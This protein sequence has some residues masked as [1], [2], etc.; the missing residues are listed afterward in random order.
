MIL[1]GRI[2]AKLCSELQ[3]CSL[4]KS[5]TDFDLVSFDELIGTGRDEDGENVEDP[6]EHGHIAG[7]VHG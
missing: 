4:L 3:S 7:P 5:Y 1:E 6:R 2:Y